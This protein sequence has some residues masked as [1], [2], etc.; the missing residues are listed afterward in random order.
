V[1]FGKDSIEQPAPGFDRLFPR[2]WNENGTPVA[3]PRSDID[4]LFTKAVFAPT[5]GFM[6][7]AVN[8]DGTP[9]TQGFALRAL[10]PDWSPSGPYA[11]VMAPFRSAAEYSFYQANRFYARVEDELPYERRASSATPTVGPL[12]PKFD[13][14][15]MLAS[16]ADLPQVMRR[17]GLVIDFMVQDGSVFDKA[18][19][20]SATVDTLMSLDVAWGGGH[21]NK[22]DAWPNTAVR[23]TKARFVQR[24][25]QPQDHAGGLLR[26]EAASDL[27]TNEKSLFDVYQVDVDGSALK[28]VNFLLTSQNLVAK[29]LALNGSIDQHKVTY[30]TGNEQGLA[31]LRSGGIGISRHG[32]SW[33]V[34][35]N[36][37]AAVLKN[38]AVQGSAAQSRK[39]VLFAEDSMRGYRIDVFDVKQAQWRSLCRRM[40]QAAVRGDPGNLIPHEPDEGYVKGASTSSSANADDADPDV[41]HYLH[42]SMFRWA[43]WSLAAPR[44]GRTIVADNAADS[45]LQ[46]ESVQDVSDE[47]E[48]GNQIIASFKA[49]PGSLP[50]LRF[51]HLYRLRARLVDLAGNSL[52]IDDPSIDPLEQATD[53]IAYRRFE[54]VDPPALVGRLR[55]SEGESLERLVIRSDFDA[56][57]KAYNT[58]PGTVFAT[59]REP[60]ETS[61]QFEYAVTGERHVV[62]PKTSQLQ[63]EQHGAFDDAF[64]GS[65]QAIAT[66]Y[67]IAAREAGTLFD[68]MPG[69][70]IELVTPPSLN[71]VATVASVPP[72]LPNPELPTGGRMAPGQYVIHREDACPTPYLPDVL[73][74]GVALLN[75]PGLTAALQLGDDTKVVALPNGKAMLCVHWSN[76]PSKWPDRQ[77]LRLVIAERAIKPSGGACDPVFVDDGTPRWNSRERTLTL[78]LA[79][80]EIARLRYSSFVGDG[81]LDH[82]GLAGWMGSAGE[83]KTLLEW[84]RAGGHWMVTPHRAL[85]LV[86]ATQHPVCAPF[87]VKTGVVRA[88]G[89][90]HVSLSGLVKMHGPS[91]GKF[92]VT[93]TWNE[94]IDDPTRGPPVRVSGSGQLPEMQLPENYTNEFTF[95]QVVVIDRALTGNANDTKPRA[96]G[97]RHEFGDTKFRHVRY[98][99]VATTRFREYLPPALYADTANVT[100][101]GPVW[102]VATLMEGAVDDP[103]APVLEGPSGTPRDGVVVRSSARPSAPRLVYSVP[104]FKW[105]RPDAQGGLAGKRSTRLGNGLRVYLERPWFSSG[106]GELLGVVL[107]GRASTAEGARFTD[108]PADQTQFVTQWGADP[109]FDSVLP[110]AAARVTD[111][112]AAVT[113]GTVTLAE[114]SD[115][116]V[117]VVGHRVQYDAARGLWFADIELDAGRN[118]MPFVRLALVRYQPNS[119]FKAEISAVVLAEFAQVL[120]RRDVYLSS[121]AAVLNLNVYGP[122][123]ERGSMTFPNDGRFEGIMFTQD[124]VGTAERGRN[125][126]EIVLQARDPLVDS[127]LA[128]TDLRVLTGGLADPPDASS[129]GGLFGAGANSK[130]LDVPIPRAL[131]A[132]ADFDIGVT[133]ANVVASQIGKAELQRFIPEFWAEAPLWSASLRLLDLP[134]DRPVRLCLREFER[135]Y[136]DRTIP[137]VFGGKTQRAKVVEERLVYAE[138]FAVPAG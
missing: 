15:Q 22:Q 51:G 126:F 69:T 116:S 65:P 93:A 66:Q 27:G 109:L 103:G 85:T 1:Q 24:E 9:S 80:G 104:T 37:A 34:A 122:G 124:P 138:F 91:T 99:L 3:Q 47:A 77:G 117:V 86:H 20:G 84:A 87:F 57:A 67:A 6:P 40:T 50:R 100:Q 94:W 134:T 125:R 4:R 123:P 48:T 128:W 135:F 42:E 110:K 129:I 74:E 89:D 45:G 97:N 8:I 52:S 43:G 105:S 41:D 18:L 108:I 2:R 68:A 127:D 62:P 26:L 76:D 83:R 75:V 82:L 14:H 46:G 17:L 107:L 96:P 60:A 73:S 55:L 30:T 63:A 25:R 16:Y 120:P 32:R 35:E 71:G 72:A 11:A 81:F 64:G 21:D 33:Q 39:I 95:E 131:D 88:L 28:T 61:G 102:D 19:S 90:T 78:F 5:T 12:P 38:T 113:S 29:S 56:D 7:R 31:A 10:P 133:F 36:A 121:A 59:A 118:Y 53:P 106:D 112:P 92:E 111:F 130:T 132:S 44:P 137:Q 136:T 101:T 119:L 49:A 79:Q 115:V 98:R 54:P 114:R 23:L 58:A 13:F 70:Q